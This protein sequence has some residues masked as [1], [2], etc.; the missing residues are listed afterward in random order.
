MLCQTFKDVS[1]PGVEAFHASLAQFHLC[2]R[3]KYNVCLSLLGITAFTGYPADEG[4]LQLAIS[5]KGRCCK[6][7]CITANKSKFFPKA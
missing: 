5:A 7:E 4:L 2:H 6:K 3:E 1:P